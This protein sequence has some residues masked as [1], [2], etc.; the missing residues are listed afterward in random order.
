MTHTTLTLIILLLTLCTVSGLTGFMVLRR[1]KRK[2]LEKIKTLCRKVKSALND[3]E[4]I[5]DAPAFAD[6]LEDAAIATGFQ[7]P[8][9]EL[10]A[11]K[12]GGVPEKYK[13]F[14]GLVARGMSTDEISEILGISPAEA[15]QLAAL[16]FISGGKGC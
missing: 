7:Q 6:T 2:E 1:R 4:G 5:R 13:F 12:I 9:L 8:R 14:T 15:G 3:N 11:G 16:A 10:Q